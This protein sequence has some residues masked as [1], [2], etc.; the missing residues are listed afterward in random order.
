[1]CKAPNHLAPLLAALLL[2]GCPPAID[3]G[4]DGGADGPLSVGPEGGLFIRGGAVLE[5]PAGAVEGA[6]ISIEFSVTDTGIPVIPGR[7][8]ISLGYRFSPATVVFK[9]PVKIS[10]P[11]LVERLPAPGIQPTEF[12][13]RRK[14]GA[15]DP[16]PLS[17]PELD[18]ALA[19]LAGRSDRLGLF[20][21]TSP[22][23]PAVETVEITPA[24]ANVRLG[25]ERQFTVSIKDQFGQE[26]SGVTVSWSAIPPRVAS[27]DSSGKA[28]GLGAGIATIKAT[29][30]GKTGTATFGV[31]GV[32]P[33]PRSFGHENPFPTGNDLRGGAAVGP[34]TFFVGD[35]ATVLLRYPDG[36][37]NRL[38][39]APATTLVAIA[40]RSATHAT[41]VGYQGTTGVL[42]ETRD[43]GD[44]S[45]LT[46]ETIRPRA[47]VDDGVFGMAVGDGDDVLIREDGGWTTAYSP[48]LESLLDVRA[49]GD[50]GFVTVGS[51]GSIY[52]FDEVTR[53]WN[54]RFQ[55]Q[56]SVLLTSARFADDA[57]EVWAVG[58]GRLWHFFNGGWSATALPAN[59]PLSELTAIG[60]VGDEVVI[61]ARADTQGY[62]LRYQPQT[63]GGTFETQ[64]LRGPQRIRAIFPA[65]ASGYAVGDLGSLY[66][67]SEV[68]GAYQELSR[69]FYGDVADLSVAAGQ[70]LIAANECVGI[71]CQGHAH[72]RYA[73]GVYAEMPLP[74]AG[75][76]T[77]A[78]LFN[79]SNFVVASPA[80]VSHFNGSSWS[81]VPLLNLDGGVMTANVL[82]LAY[83]GPEIWAVGAGVVFRGGATGLQRQGGYG[84][85]LTGIQCRTASNIWIAGDRVLYENGVSRTTPNVNHGDWRAVWSQGPG[86]SLVVGDARYGLRWDTEKLNIFDAPGGLLPEVFT[87][88]HG[89]SPENIYLVGYTVTPYAFGYAVRHDGVFYELVDLG[90]QRQPTAIHG[91]SES[92]I[93]I[94]TRGGGVLRALP[95]P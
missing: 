65:G 37:F 87:G 32:T 18:T 94:G 93:F 12:D 41:A 60:V 79:E 77:A 33:G 19:L 59:P 80:G 72:F 44:P 71:F 90:S 67:K 57:A 70:V 58:G 40:P 86:E 92:A 66:R 48:S 9:K 14:A 10:V 17:G 95:P 61:G 29:A 27:V 24:E 31:Q 56:L 68:S 22:E 53:T 54:S 55:T 26:M 51:R 52:E 43:G 8:R 74:P 34:F 21:V 45:F 38:F 42:L 35:N 75:E 23:Q 30:A 76:L 28:L 5:V 13:L 88:I 36:N 63:D 81:N 73:T 20:W 1:M 7:R 69:G 89:S 16:N 11:Y 91:S 85:T 39:S 84:G 83:C 4:V 49:L 3:V 82:D 25:G 47:L 6:P 15:E 46:F 50:G 2:F 78:A 62:L 64:T